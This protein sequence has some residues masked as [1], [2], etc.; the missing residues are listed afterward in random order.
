METRR[1]PRGG[2]SQRMWLCRVGVLSQD[3][4]KNFFDCHACF[5]SPWAAWAN[6]FILLSLCDL[7]R[8]EFFSLFDFFFID[9]TLGPWRNENRR[10]QGL[11]QLP[12]ELSCTT[13][14]PI[15]LTF[16]NLSIVS[17]IPQLLWGFKFPF[18]KCSKW[19][20]EKRHLPNSA[21]CCIASS[22]TCKTWICWG[23]KKRLGHMGVFPNRGDKI[24]PDEIQSGLVLSGTCGLFTL[25]GRLGWQEVAKSL[26]NTTSFHHDDILPLNLPTKQRRYQRSGPEVLMEPWA[27]VTYVN[28][29]IEHKKGSV[30][31]NTNAWM[32]P[33]G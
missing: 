9:L 17:A 13:V 4:R 14:E 23:G 19:V 25:Q 30:A 21:P 3:Q 15:Y 24:L 5:K 26:S 29:G 10:T 31:T 20:P 12:S 22:V 16:L 1:H 33:G 11:K 2:P 32:C 6:S 7:L 28:R 8:L 18:F 27:G